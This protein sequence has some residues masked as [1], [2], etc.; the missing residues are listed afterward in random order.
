MNCCLS[1]G[2]YTYP[3]PDDRETR[4]YGEKQHKKWTRKQLNLFLCFFFLNPQ[5]YRRLFFALPFHSDALFLIFYEIL[6][7]YMHLFP[8]E[9]FI[10]ISHAV[11]A[12]WISHTMDGPFDINTWEI[13]CHKWMKEESFIA[14]FT[15][16]RLNFSLF[17]TS[18]LI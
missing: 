2:R 4:S 12:S 1:I 13:C 17:L 3:C 16:S 10:V 18:E 9:I 7:A 6:C 15:E 5:I 11:I 14:S 8:I